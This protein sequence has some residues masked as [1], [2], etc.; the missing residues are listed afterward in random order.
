MAIRRAGAVAAAISLIGIGCAT[1]AVR[2]AESRSGALAIEAAGLRAEWA[3]QIDRC[4]WFGPSAGGNMLHTVDLDQPPGADGDYTF[5]GGCYTWVAPQNGPLGWK[6]PDGAQ[7]GWP[8]DPAMDIGPARVTGISHNLI[9]TTG[10]QHLSG[11]IERKTL[12]L[13]YGLQAHLAYSLHNVGGQ[14]VIAGTWVTTAVGPHDLIAVRAPE[15]TELRGWDGSSVERFRSILGEPDAAG[16]A[17]VDLHRAAWEGGV[18]VYLERTGAHETQAEIAVWRAGHWFLRQ[19]ALLTVQDAAR[20]REVGEGPVAIYIE[21]GS[22]IVEAELY[23]PIVDMAPGDRTTTNE[24][25][26]V[27]SAAKGE[28]SA[29]PQ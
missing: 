8:P 15:G 28:R 1:P 11:L 3:A 17:L 2:P 21:P 23:G 18:K 12:M 7:R 5:F 4:V 10:P 29:L 14:R 13:D 26:S 27:I 25:W 16:W 19:G 6:D 24:L 20:L 9:T 22:G